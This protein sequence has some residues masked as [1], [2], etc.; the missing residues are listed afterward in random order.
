MVNTCVII[1]AVSI[2]VII[3]IFFFFFSSSLLLFFSSSP[4]RHPSNPKRKKG[5][6]KIYEIIKNHHLFFHHIY[7]IIF[8]TYYQENM[9]GNP[10]NFIYLQGESR[11]SFRV[12]NQ[13]TFSRTARKDSRSS[14]EGHEEVS[15][16]RYQAASLQRFAHCERIVPSAEGSELQG[17]QRDFVRA[18]PDNIL[19]G[20]KRACG[21]SFSSRIEF[22]HIVL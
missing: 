18:I 14:P 20:V 7:I 13:T 9:K 22:V 15:C 2:T 6:Q 4:T 17:T 10:L 21:S 12:T 1:T 16:N 11:A 3:F 5:D 8:L 19:A